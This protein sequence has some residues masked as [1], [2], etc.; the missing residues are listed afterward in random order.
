MFFNK[1]GL[2]KEPTLF[3]QFDNNLLSEINNVNPSGQN[4]ITYVSGK[5]N[6]AANFNGTTS[7]ITYPATTNMNMS[8]GN[9]IP[10]SVNF[11][12]KVSDID[13]NQEMRI[14]DHTRPTQG[15]MQWH[16]NKIAGNAPFFFRMYS[17][18]NQVAF[19]HQLQVPCDI[20]YNQWTMYTFTYNGLGLVNGIKS[21]RNGVLFASQGNIVNQY[22][23]MVNTSR[24]YSIGRRPDQ[25]FSYYRG[26]LDLL[27]VHKSV[28]LSPN[29][30]N[31][32]Y[33]SGNGRN[34]NEL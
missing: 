11:W 33:N 21:Y 25:A 13:I 28:I 27:S 14:I 16:V 23:K 12:A 24:V 30:I 1:T 8:N 15:S 34:F 19:S 32:L 9:D 10:F 31:Y 20:V 2:S 4:A 26:D 22:T 29:E 6:Q 18:T 17:E 7:F 3:Y 5:K